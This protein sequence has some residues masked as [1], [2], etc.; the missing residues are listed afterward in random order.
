MT[1]VDPLNAAIRD[2]K[3][4]R[5]WIAELAMRQHG[6][7]AHW[8]VIRGGL[9]SSGIHRLIEAGWLHP[10]H[11]GVYAVGHRR[12]TW[13]GRCSAAVLACGPIALL[14]HQPAAALWEV[15]RSS[16]PGATCHR[17][18]PE[19]GPARPNGS[20]RAVAP[21]RGLRGA[22]RHRR[23][24]PFPHPAR[25][26]RGAAVAAGRAGDRGGRAAT[27]LRP[28]RG[29]AAAGSQL[30]VDALW[31]NAWARRAPMTQPGEGLQPYAT[32][33]RRTWA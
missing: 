29:G 6:V 22:R 17:A 18:A 12:V 3:G 2:R 13:L 26:R 20:P 8:Q 19:E 14:S 33:L 24:Q 9:S 27:D 32:R 31:R 21:S 15:R 5:Q 10:L 25:Q 4:P 23:H 30:E 7:V 1:D 28:R 16:S 11:I